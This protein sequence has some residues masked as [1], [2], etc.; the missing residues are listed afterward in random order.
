[1]ARR[2]ETL[3]EPPQLAGEWFTPPGTRCTMEIRTLTPMVGGG[4]VSGVIDHKSPVHPQAI[5][6]HLRFWW[7]ATSGARWHS[8]KDL[9]EQEER[10]WGSQRR[11]GVVRIGVREV[12]FCAGPKVLSKDK[13]WDAQHRDALFELISKG[14]A[15]S[16]SRRRA[17]SDEPPPLAYVSFPYGSQR[18]GQPATAAMV[19]FLLDIACDAD[20]KT[21]REVYA[22][23]WAWVHFGGIGSRTRRGMGAL[24]CPAWVPELGAGTNVRNTVSQHVHQ[25]WRQVGVELPHPFQDAEWPVLSRWVALGRVT[26]VAAAWETAAEALRV[27]R[28]GP[29]IG[30][31]SSKG[32]SL[33]PEP[34]TIRDWTGCASER[35]RDPLVAVRGFPRAVFGLPIRFQF[36]SDSGRQSSK[37]PRYEEPADA[38]LTPKGYTRWPSPV[39]LRPVAVRSGDQLR[40][41]PMLA[42]LNVPYPAEYRIKFDRVAGDRPLW[43]T[44]WRESVVEPSFARYDKSPLAGSPEGHALRAFLQFVEERWSGGGSGR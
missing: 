23:L 37:D 6:G 8:V 35:H 3:P 15:V 26:D 21:F 11:T 41:V 13:G 42:L 18:R 44:L 2:D 34:D 28:Q 20:E 4:V 14:H 16:V 38:W 40:A 25:P 24:Y 10:I 5:R 33:W 1:M 32:R 29:K 22:A 7:R 43:R 19:S 31:T 17:K 12:Q 36:K 9:W 39:I 27:F 30:R